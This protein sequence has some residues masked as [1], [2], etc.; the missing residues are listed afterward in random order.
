MRGLRASLVILVFLTLLTGVAYPW[1]MTGLAQWLWPV[2]ANGSLVQNQA[3]HVIGSVWIGQYF[4]DNP[5]Y[6]WGRPSATE[7]VPY[8]ASG[9][10]GSNWGPS[11]KVLQARIEKRILQLQ[12]ADPGNSQPIPID[13]VTA[14]G[15]GLDPHITLAAAE[16]QVNRVARTRNRSP[17]HVRNL[18]NSSLEPRT[19]GLL[20]EPRVN[21]LRLN[22]ALDQKLK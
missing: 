22:I 4:E 17:E 14:S 15:S 5:A 10:A 3:G 8:A 9:S 11:S 7:P 21:V 2:Q 18:V 16:Y 6:F 1:T 13:L 20:G 12:Q 19:L